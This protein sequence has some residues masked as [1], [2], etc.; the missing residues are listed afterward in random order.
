MF[1]VGNADN[2]EVG[3]ENGGVAR[4]GDHRLWEQRDKA[5]NGFGSGVEES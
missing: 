3:V 5:V 2:G 1:S 4:L